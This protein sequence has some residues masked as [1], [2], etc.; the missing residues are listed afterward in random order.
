MKHD[1][2]FEWI[3]DTKPWSKETLEYFELSRLLFETDGPLTSMS[4]G[5]HVSQE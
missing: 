2:L 1:R 3:E 5:S 4:P